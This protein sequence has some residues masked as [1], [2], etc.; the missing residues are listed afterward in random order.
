MIF[1]RK[2][3]LY[4]LQLILHEILIQN[5]TSDM[6][7]NVSDTDIAAVSESVKYAVIIVATMPVLCVYPFLQKYF[8]KGVMVGAVKE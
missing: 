1:L 3:T 2:R 8:T 7:V 6:T 4:P 5:D